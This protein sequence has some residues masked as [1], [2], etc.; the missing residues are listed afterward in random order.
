M[1]RY[2]QLAL[3]DFGA[4]KAQRERETANQRELTSTLVMEPAC[5]CSSSSLLAFDWP[6]LTRRRFQNAAEC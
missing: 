1:D 5:A 4:E 6:N 2:P 3:G